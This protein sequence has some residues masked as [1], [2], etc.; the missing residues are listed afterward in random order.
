MVF[1][2]G[3][4]VK[5]KRPEEELTGIV[6]GSTGGFHGVYYKVELSNGTV[7]SALDKDTEEAE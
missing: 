3:T 7:I 6:R 1:T 2:S 5:V 4:K